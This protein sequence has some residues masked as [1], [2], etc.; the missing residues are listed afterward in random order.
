M[1]TRNIL[2][3]AVCALSG[4]CTLQAA[5]IVES[6]APAQVQ[7]AQNE[8]PFFQDMPYPAWSQLTP[9]QALKDAR[10]AI[11]RVYARIDAICQIKPEE[12]TFENTFLALA[13]ASRELDQVQGYMHHLS[14]VMDS[15][16]MREAQ[17]ELLPELNQLSADIN[18]NEQLWTVIKS[19]AAQ[20]WVKQL[21]PQKQRFVQQTVDSFRD[22]GADLSPEKK[23]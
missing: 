10:V 8:H 21:S 6:V 7:T 14:S 1:T 22:S 12:A 17:K 4:L 11:K 2:L 18:S 19:A 13:E 23:A 20:P 3:T 16:E 9:E 15:P 5:E